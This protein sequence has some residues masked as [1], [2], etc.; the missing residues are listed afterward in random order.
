[1]KPT[2]SGFTLIELM[3]V[4]AI[5]AILGAVAYP[6]IQL[7]VIRQQIESIT[8]LTDV[9]KKPIAAAWASTQKMPADNA[10]AGLPSA[11][12]MV[13]NFV[14]EVKVQDGA[15]NITF[16]NQ[17]NNAIK[18]KVLTMRPAV[19]TDAPI[20]PVTWVCGAADVPDKM[21]VLGVDQTTVPAG[22]LPLSCLK[23]VK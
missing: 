18:G 16:G 9:A 3:V 14:S 7:R 8:P 21:T 11:D 6:S 10:A 1:M 17:V 4:V 23:R 5:I 20:V 2:R 15:I 22:M 19:V 13:S 12:K